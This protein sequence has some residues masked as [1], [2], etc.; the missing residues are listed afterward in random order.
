[1]FF[2]QSQKPSFTPVKKTTGKI[3][4]LHIL[5]IAHQNLDC[6]NIL[7]ISLSAKE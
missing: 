1:M 6:F 4:T 7:D 3:V 2:P 5:I